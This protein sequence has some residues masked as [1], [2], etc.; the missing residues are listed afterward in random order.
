M[1]VEDAD[2]PADLFFSDAGLFHRDAGKKEEKREEKED[3]EATARLFWRF[4]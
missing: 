1:E 2:E 3:G 4:R